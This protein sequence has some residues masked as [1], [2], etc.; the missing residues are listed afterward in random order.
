MTTL[1]VKPKNKKELS[2]AKKMLK[3]LEISFEDNDDKPYNPAFVKKILRS[4]KEYQEGKGTT[5]TI[6]ELNNL[7][8]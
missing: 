6:E 8:K 7:W 1:I 3:V 5:I 2:K 4:K